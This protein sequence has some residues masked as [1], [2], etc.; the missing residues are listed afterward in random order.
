MT[1]VNYQMSVFKKQNIVREFRVRP[2]CKYLFIFSLTV[3]KI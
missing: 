2:V 1:Y 3:V